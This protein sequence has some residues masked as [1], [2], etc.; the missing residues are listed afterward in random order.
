MIRD[1]LTPAQRAGG[2]LIL[3]PDHGWGLGMA[4]ALRTTAEGVPAGAYGWSGGLGTS[5]MADPRSG[6]TA[7]LMTQT[8]FENPDPPAVHKDFWRAVFGPAEG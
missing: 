3:G 5:W 8:M 6:L 2:R 1:H 4:V 7:I